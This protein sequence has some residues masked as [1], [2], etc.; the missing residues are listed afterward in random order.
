MINFDELKISAG[1]ALQADK[2]NDL[3]D[4]LKLEVP[5]NLDDKELVLTNAE[6]QRNFHLVADSFDA[7]TASL[8]IEV[9]SDTGSINK[10][11]LSL[12]E[13]GAQIDGPLKVQT[14]H[15]YL[16]LGPKNSSWAHFHT[17]R[18][19][20]YFNREIR[21]DSGRIGSYNENLYLCTTGT[22]RVTV[23]TAG[24]VGIGTSAPAE[25]LH[26]VGGR[27]RLQ[28]PGTGKLIDM[29]T[30]G[31]ENDI[32]SYNAD[33]YLSA[34]GSGNR[35]VVNDQLRVT[36]MPFGNF[37]NVQWNSATGVL[38]YDNSSRRFKENIR[39]LDEDFEAILKARPKTYTRPGAPDRQEIGFIAEDF[40]DLGLFPLVDYDE[41]GLP[42]ILRY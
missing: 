31:A 35:V 27:I 7:S 22:T 28:K 41:K 10:R 1:T 8:N 20:Y 34:T 37:K 13:N 3:V 12:H 18:A 21:V 38:G 26:V 24:R 9:K 33:L 4:R 29:R 19:K 2:W 36:S 16:D 25:Q 23:T 11:L 6:K 14:D 30:D 5:A 42:E 15:G 39:D 17:D 40:H 32:T